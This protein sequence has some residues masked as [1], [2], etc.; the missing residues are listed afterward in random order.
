MALNGAGRFSLDFLI[1]R[2]IGMSSSPLKAFVMRRPQLDELEDFVG[3]PVST[4][5]KY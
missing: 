5:D 4:S 1:I 2:A 3:V